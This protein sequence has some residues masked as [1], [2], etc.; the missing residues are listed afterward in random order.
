MAMAFEEMA[1]DFPGDVA[2]VAGGANGLGVAIAK[3]LAEKG[4]RVYISGDLIENKRQIVEL[5][6]IACGLCAVLPKHLSTAEE[7]LAEVAEREDNVNILIDD[8]TDGWG[9]VF[10]RADAFFDMLLS[11]SGD[12][13]DPARI[14]AVMSSANPAGP[15]DSKVASAEN[16]RALAAE[17]SDEC[18][19][20]NCIEPA[21]TEGDTR[22]VVDMAISM[23][24][25]P[26]A[27]ANGEVSCVD[28]MGVSVPQ[29]RDAFPFLHSKL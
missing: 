11:G 26:S 2:V 29:K 25:Q 24:A 20:V 6:S 27:H 9:P 12:A 18:I 16:A 22:N 7:L 17:F 28:D 19:V 14:I 4:A 23:C 8:A 21:K 1:C 10:A 13:S 15:W 5:S 3:A